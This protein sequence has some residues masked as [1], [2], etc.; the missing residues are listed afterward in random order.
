MH[1]LNE[2]SRLQGEAN[3]IR[4]RSKAAALDSEARAR[5]MST[6]RAL[7]EEGIPIAA[8]WE[9]AFGIPYPTSTS[10]STHLSSARPPSTANSSVASYRSR[11]TSTAPDPYTATADPRHH[12]GH[13]LNQLSRGTA[14]RDTSSH[15]SSSRQQSGFVPASSISR[16][17]NEI[18]DFDIDED[19]DDGMIDGGEDDAEQED[20]SE[21]SHS[22]P[23]LPTDRTV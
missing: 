9:T 13:Y 7:K 11:S 20:V 4:A 14:N 16:K 10:S 15:G 19:D 22:K 21:V 1:A 17:T 5:N 2:A 6:F 12:R 23:V 8:A 18:Q 3:M